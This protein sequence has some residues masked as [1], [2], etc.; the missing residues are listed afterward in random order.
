MRWI[1]LEGISWISTLKLKIGVNAHKKS[2]TVVPN[3]VA[4]E[5]CGI[6]V[7]FNFP[8]SKLSTVLK[9]FRPTWEWLVS[10]KEELGVQ[11]V[12]GNITCISD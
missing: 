12:C 2:F 11:A 8:L 1:G 5:C 9:K 7:D 10:G 6:A 4:H 3:S